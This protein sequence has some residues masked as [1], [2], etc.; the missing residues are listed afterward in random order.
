MTGEV[1]PANLP[2]DD[3][4]IEDH[5][6]VLRRL[7]DAGPSMVAVDVITGERRPTSGAFA[8]DADGVSVYRESRLRAIGMT[9]AD[10]VKS[11]QNLVVALGIGEIRSLAQLGVRDDPWP[12]DIVDAEHPRNAAHALITGWAGLSRSE[13]R[14]R[15]RTLTRLPSLRFL[16]P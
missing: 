15:Q 6:S 2:S 7:S 13:R 11:P 12:A 3:P 16:H 1:Q 9:A 4:A 14:E 8:P 10:L 5:D